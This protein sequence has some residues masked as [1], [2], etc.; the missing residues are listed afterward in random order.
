MDYREG[1]RGGQQV[2]PASSREYADAMCFANSLFDDPALWAAA[3]VPHMAAVDWSADERHSA[4]D[5]VFAGAQCP[6]GG[7]SANPLEKPAGVNITGT[8]VFSGGIDPGSAA[9]QARAGGW[10]VC[11]C[12]CVCVCVRGCVE[13]EG[14]GRVCVRE[15]V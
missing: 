9:S 6:V 2:P 11:A 12:V 3:G 4:P 1:G 5:C 10:C 7:Q 15:T 13:G 14:G 8:I